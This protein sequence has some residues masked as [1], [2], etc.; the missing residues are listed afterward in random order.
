[1]EQTV[2]APGLIRFQDNTNATFYLIIGQERALA[3]DSGM[4]REPVMPLLR[5]LTDL[6]IAL[7][8]THAHGDHYGAAHAFDTVY[9]HEKDAAVLPC[10]QERFGPAMG[11]QPIRPDTLQAVKQGDIIELGGL[12]VRVLDL[13]GHTPGSCAFVD[14]VH[15]CV[16]TGDAIGS[17][18][19][20]W[21]QV[22]LALTVSEYRE[23]LSRFCKIA[24]PYVDYTFLAGHYT[25]AGEPGSDKYNPPSFQMAQDML[26]LCEHLLRGEIPLEATAATSF[27][28]E[29]AKFARYKS[30]GMVLYA[31]QIK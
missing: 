22:P 6:P 27:S 23:S 11:I 12:C 19:G 14:S 24:A 7:A 16:F 1:M 4:G 31:S 21:M 20:V 9:M 13:C 18:I 8:V 5:R 25:Q 29:P 26:E 15:Q 10:M 17:G 2:L 30:A 3:I 28:L